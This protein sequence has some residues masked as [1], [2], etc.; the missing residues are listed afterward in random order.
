MKDL[1]NNIFGI[2][3]TSTIYMLFGRLKTL[4]MSGNKGLKTLI[5]M[6][7]ILSQ[8]L[9]VMVFDW[10][11]KPAGQKLDMSKFQLVWSDEF[12]GTKVDSNIWGGHYVY[13]DNAEARCGGFWHN[14]MASVSDGNLI[15]KAEYLDVGRG[16]KGPG[17]YSYGMDTRGRYEQCY[18]YFEVRCKMPAAQGLWSAFW[19]LND[20]TY[21]VNGNG[22]DG[23][24]VDVFESPFYKDA[25]WGGGNDIV[26]GVEYDGYGKDNQSMSIGKYRVAGDPYT[27]FHTYGLEWNK[28]EYI[29]YVDGVETGRTNFG[30]VSQNAEWLILSV[31]ISGANGVANGDNHGT[32][33]IAK[34][35]NWPAEFI[36]DYVRAYQYKELI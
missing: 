21:D 36:V 8:I 2:R 34:N 33:Y 18:G 26:S 35:K 4:L 5:S 15:I 22:K 1:F 29:F 32:G 25:W 9:G 12:N 6:I 28:D 24:E 17:Y 10:G 3:Q 31:E 14:S 23:T 27:E 7:L 20:S 30:G 11:M 19:M 16:G 13:G